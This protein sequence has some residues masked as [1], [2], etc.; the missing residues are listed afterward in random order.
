MSVGGL[1]G[2]DDDCP[3]GDGGGDVDDGPQWPPVRRRSVAA[4]EER[5]GCDEAGQSYSV[6]QYRHSTPQSS[7]SQKHCKTL[8]KLNRG[9]SMALQTIDPTGQSCKA[10]IASA[11]SSFTVI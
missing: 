5:E 4:R 11:V 3:G 6:S 10:I 8:Q 2:G 1:E 9:N 7:T